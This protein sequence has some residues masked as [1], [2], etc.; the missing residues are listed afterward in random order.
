MANT[1][2]AT[3]AHHHNAAPAEFATIMPSS[4]LIPMQCDCCGH[5]QNIAM[6]SLRTLPQITCIECEDQRQFSEFELAVLEK[7]LK[8]MGYFISK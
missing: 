4:T 5:E 8:E 3:D 1:R 2:R 6:K 7:A